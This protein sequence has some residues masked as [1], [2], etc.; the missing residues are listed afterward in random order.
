MNA[1]IHALMRDLASWVPKNQVPVETEARIA[2]RALVAFQ[3]LTDQ[4]LD[5]LCKRVD[6][7]GP[8][9]CPDV[10]ARLRASIA[11]LPKPRQRLRDF[12]ECNDC[13]GERFA[14]VPYLI[15]GAD[16]EDGPWHEVYVHFAKRFGLSWTEV[17][18]DIDTDIISAGDRIL[19]C[20]SVVTR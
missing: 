16:R 12:I 20:L 4:V 17:E 3:T 11:D 5:D 8:R 7:F 6:Q 1:P 18:H 2:G 13:D 19:G 10:V 15:A 14:L 9:T